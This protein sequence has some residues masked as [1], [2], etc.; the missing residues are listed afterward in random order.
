MSE[1]H[2]GGA[3]AAAAFG[4]LLGRLRRE[5]DERLGRT[6]VATAPALPAA[7]HPHAAKLK[8]DAEAVQDNRPGEQVFE[9]SACAT[10]RALVQALEARKPSPADVELVHFLTDQAVQQD[11]AGQPLTRFR[12]RC[13]FVGSDVRTAVKQGLADYLPVSLARV[14]QLIRSGRIPVDVALLQVSPPDA[15]GWVSCGV[16]VD[17]APAAVARARLVIAEVN[18][19][20][21]R[22]LGEALLHVDDIDWL[23]PVDTP[24]IEYLHPLLPTPVVERIARYIGGIIDD[25]AT[26]QIGL[27]RVSHE[28]LKYLAGRRNLGNHT[29]VVTDALVP[30]IEQGVVNGFHKTHH[31]RRISAS[32]A[33]GTRRLYDLIDNNPLFDFQPIDTLCDPAVLA[34]QHRLVSI[35]QAFA[36]D[37]TGQVC[38]DQLNGEFYGGV[39]A[40]AEF[41]RAAAQSEG[42]KAIVCLQSTDGDEGASR[43]RDALQPGEGVAI[44]RHDVHY[45]VTEYGIA[46]LFGKSLRERAVALIGLAHPKFRP[47]LLEAAK[48]RG[49]VPAELQLR[50]LQAYAVEEEQPLALKD[51]RH[52]LLRPA[53]PSDADGIRTLFHGLSQRDVYTRFFRSVKSLSSQ[54]VQ[55]LCNLDFD[56]EVAFVAVT[57]PRE[58]E[59]VVGHAVYVAE[60][61]TQLAETA[62]MLHNEWQGQG[63]GSALQRC[64]RVHAERHGV[65]G[66]V[67]EI[68]NTNEPMIRLAKAGASQVSTQAE[69][70]TVRVTAL[71]K[72]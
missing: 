29:D 62:F 53:T 41:M 48:A 68:L 27:G 17:I 61:A 24:V 46:Y 10:P 31:P 70:G 15:F 39:A 57:G 66:F 13:F 20:M 38:A 64:M 36:V 71:F 3:P 7:Q 52:V 2:T 43:I 55:R 6:P 56:N 21:P 67:A 30:L 59:R 63:L 9:G 49:L 12:H 32:F 37:L 60:P 34:Q 50:N 69:G 22:T 44:A 23:V 4:R 47:A 18:P 45:V 35:T 51:G 54:D 42:G 33:M 14:P 19:H 5:V 11:D 65:Q 26:L 40:Q 16:S 25:G 8:S 58:Q 1:E 72:A 28:A